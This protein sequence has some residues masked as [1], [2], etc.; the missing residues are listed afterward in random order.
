M[1]SLKGTR[2]S[3]SLAV[4][5]KLEVANRYGEWFVKREMLMW[6]EWMFVNS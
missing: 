1:P 4:W 5:S 2:A 3:H 6:S